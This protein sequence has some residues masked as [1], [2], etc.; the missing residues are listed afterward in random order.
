MQFGSIGWSVGATLGYAQALKG[1]KRVIASIG[2]GSFQVTA[3]V[4]LAFFFFS[5]FSSFSSSSSSFYCLSAC[6]SSSSTRFH[7][8]LCLLSSSLS[9][10]AWDTHV[11]YFPSPAVMLS[12][13]S[14]VWARAQMTKSVALHGMC[15][16]TWTGPSHT[17]ERQNISF[18]MPHSD[19]IC[20]N[21]HNNHHNLQAFQLLVLARYLVGEP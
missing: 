21:H 3:Q 4:W 1:K 13:L 20:V 19:L 16:D 8:T 18:T 2:D 9:L 10:H 12:I 15:T 11:N 14:Q 6:H 5:S 17:H 7:A